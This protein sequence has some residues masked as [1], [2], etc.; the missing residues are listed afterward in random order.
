MAQI[1][2]KLVNL[3]ELK[4]AKK[5]GRIPIFYSE[6]EFGSDKTSGRQIQ[7]CGLFIHGGRVYHTLNYVT[8]ADK[9][10]ISSQIS[11]AVGYTYVYV[12][13]EFYI[14]TCTTLASGDT[15]DYTRSGVSYRGTMLYNSFTRDWMIEHIA[16][17]RPLA[18]D[19][20]KYTQVKSTVR[21]IYRLGGITVSHEAK[22]NNEVFQY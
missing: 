14:N 4:L 13:D 1:F 10:L 11:L 12:S 18:I 7:G 21:M 19:Y 9:E 3:E 8:N 17:S 2:K 20:L 6:N 16:T 22:K 5:S 15:V